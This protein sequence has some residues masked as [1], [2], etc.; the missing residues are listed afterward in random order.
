MDRGAPSPQYLCNSPES[1]NFFPLI[2]VLRETIRHIT[3]V[4]VSQTVL[5]QETS[6]FPMGKLSS[7][8][9]ITTYAAADSKQ[10]KSRQKSEVSPNCLKY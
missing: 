8:G 1:Q 7:P 6:L 3:T 10:L 9:G 5:C 4:S 2:A